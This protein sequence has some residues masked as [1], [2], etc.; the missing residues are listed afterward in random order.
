MGRANVPFLLLRGGGGCGE[1]VVSCVVMHLCL[2]RLLFW[3]EVNCLF[4]SRAGVMRGLFIS[5]TPALA[6]G[7]VLLD[8]YRIVASSYPGLNTRYVAVSSRP[9]GGSLCASHP[10]PI[11]GGCCRENEYEL[12]LTCVLVVIPHCWWLVALV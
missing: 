10:C 12:G 4:P 11:S 8:M 9:E 6:R 2:D 3:R 5:S 7:I 1:R